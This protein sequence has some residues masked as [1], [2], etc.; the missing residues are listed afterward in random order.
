[1]NAKSDQSDPID[2]LSELTADE[3]AER[4]SRLDSE[5]ASLSVLLRAARARERQLARAKALTTNGGRR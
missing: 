5:R 4:I 1:M 2:L 3:L